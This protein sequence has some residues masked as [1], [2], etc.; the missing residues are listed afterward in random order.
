MKNALAAAETYGRS[1]RHDPS[2]HHGARVLLAWTTA[3]PPGERV[4]VTV[5][6]GV[7]GNERHRDWRRRWL[8][9]RRLRRAANYAAR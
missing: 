6:S 2:E 8:P 9:A 1:V 4:K 7:C 5:P 3:L